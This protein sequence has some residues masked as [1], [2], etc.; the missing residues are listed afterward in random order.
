MTSE[1]WF[2]DAGNFAAGPIAKVKLGRRLRPQ[3]HGWWVP[4]AELVAAGQP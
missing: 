2:I 3:I 1:L 4:R